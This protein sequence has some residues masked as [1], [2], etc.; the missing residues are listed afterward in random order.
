MIDASLLDLIGV[1]CDAFLVPSL[2][3]DPCPILACCLGHLWIS[4]GRD[5]MDG[6]Q[7]GAEGPLALQLQLINATVR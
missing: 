5:S 4:P 3:R 1:P 2:K 6:S 7:N